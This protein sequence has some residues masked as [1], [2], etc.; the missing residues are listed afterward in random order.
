MHKTF[1][2]HFLL[3]FHKDSPPLHCATP[4]IPRPMYFQT[5]ERLEKLSLLQNLF[6][7]LELVPSTQTIVLQLP[8][9]GRIPL[10]W[11]I[12]NCLN[13][14]V[15][16]RRTYSSLQKGP[17]DARYLAGITERWTVEIYH[18][19]KLLHRLRCRLFNASRLFSGCYHPRGLSRGE[20]ARLIRFR[21]TDTFPSEHRWPRIFIHRCA[22]LGNWWGTS[23][24]KLREQPR[25][26]LS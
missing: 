1:I 10:R 26:A 24:S 25:T 13:P 8:Y 14:S 6:T 5:S 2:L 21:W 18:A 20:I 11:P 7:S 4:Y 17:E 12:S 15:R 16:A 22:T 9:S 3:F 19:A 23:R